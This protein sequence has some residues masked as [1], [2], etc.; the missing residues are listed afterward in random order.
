M[1]YL[2]YLGTRWHLPKGF[3]YMDRE[4]TSTRL[5]HNCSQKKKKKIRAS[6]RKQEKPH[7]LISLGLLCL[8]ELDRARLVPASLAG[9]E[10]VRHVCTADLIP[11]DEEGLREVVLVAIELVVD[12][13]VSAVVAEEDMEDVPGEPQ[14][15]VVIDSLDGREREEEYARPWGHA[16]DEE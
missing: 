2:L 3:Y 14:A 4:N 10:G 13:M 16:R 8:A 12:V 7:S 15:A 6:R 9:L 11:H 5:Q 1:F